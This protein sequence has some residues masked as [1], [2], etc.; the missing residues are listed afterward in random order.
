[1]GTLDASY[2][3]ELNDDED[4][5][6]AIIADPQP[7]KSPSSSPK[8]TYH[9]KHSEKKHADHKHLIDED[10]DS[11][12]PSPP[13]LPSSPSLL[14]RKLIRRKKAA[15]TL[16]VMRKWLQKIIYAQAIGNV[17][18]ALPIFIMEKYLI[19]LLIFFEVFFYPYSLYCT[20]FYSFLLSHSSP[21]S[22]LF[23]LDF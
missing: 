4:E 7:P 20:T 17:I 16:R 12:I 11:L 15:M 3:N 14:P 13:P 10:E 19:M 23:L 21:L 5:G 1:M 22:L 6:G 2:N 18:R 9:N 8:H